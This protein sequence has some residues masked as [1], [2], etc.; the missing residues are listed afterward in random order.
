MSRAALVPVAVL[1]LCA[2]AALGLRWGVT[3]EA[4]Q[5]G[6]DALIASD[7]AFAAATAADGIEGWM[8]FMADDAARMPELGAEIVAASTAR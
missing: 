1:G 6:A 7:E 2:A 5:S 8:S 4:A 3:A